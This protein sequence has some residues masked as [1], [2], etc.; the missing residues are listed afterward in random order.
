MYQSVIHSMAIFDEKRYP[1]ACV[2]PPVP[3]CFLSQLDAQVRRTFFLLFLPMNKRICAF[4]GPVEKCL[5]LVYALCG[6]RSLH[7]FLAIDNKSKCLLQSPT[8]STTWMKRRL[9]QD[10]AT[11]RSLPT[12]T[13]AREKQVI[14]FSP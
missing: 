3:K 13:Y 12:Y 7:F 1:A 4:Y 8:K 6:V 5:S 9:V 2:E 11:N 14:Y 10:F